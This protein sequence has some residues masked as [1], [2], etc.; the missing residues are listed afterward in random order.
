M[1]REPRFDP[2]FDDDNPEWTEADFARAK[3][4]SAFPELEAAL[5]RKPGRPTGTTRSD[6]KQVTLRIPTRVIEHFK[7]G[8]PGWQ[9]RAVAALEKAAREG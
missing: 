7:R 9:T 2:Q 6:R 5:K 4:L 3:P 8:G 1:S